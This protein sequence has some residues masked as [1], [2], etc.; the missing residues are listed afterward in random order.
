MTSA[1][2]YELCISANATTKLALCSRCRKNR[3]CSSECQRLDW[4]SHKK[5]CVPFSASQSSE[6]LN[7]IQK[8]TDKER[9]QYN[10]KSKSELINFY[11]EY[12][13]KANT[14][15]ELKTRLKNMTYALDLEENY[16]RR[17]ESDPASRVSVMALLR[18]LGEG[19]RNLDPPTAAIDYLLRSIELSKFSFPQSLQRNAW[20]EQFDCHEALGNIYLNIDEV[21]LAEPHCLEALRLGQIVYRG[22]DLRGNETEFVKCINTY[23]Y[24]RGKQGDIPDCVAHY[25]QAYELLTSIPDKD[26]DMIDTAIDNLLEAYL[27]GR[28]FEKAQLFLTKQMARMKSR[29]KSGRAAYAAAKHRLAETLLQSKNFSEAEIAEGEAIDIFE[30]SHASFSPNFSRALYTMALARMFQHKYDEETEAYFLRSL[31]IESVQSSATSLNV[32]AIGS[33]FGSFY[34]RRGDLPRALERFETALEIFRQRESS[35]SAAVA[36]IERNIADIREGKML[37]V[38]ANGNPAVLE[39]S[40]QII[41]GWVVAWEM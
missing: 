10:G 34:Y 20:L 37:P 6:V 38:D 17:F 1:C 32:A 35:S 41:P 2:D 36:G 27:N 25:E 4:K 40:D 16:L 3:Y 11:S 9:N 8:K 39:A 33:H 21:A 29:G 30:K 12:L 15:S 7:S 19:H 23:A 14:A 5:N 26:E 13:R 31:E 24:L 22:T 28:I 18:G